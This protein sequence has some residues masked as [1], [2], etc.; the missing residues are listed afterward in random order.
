MARRSTLRSPASGFRWPGHNT[1]P[2]LTDGGR[3]DT[4][5]RCGDVPAHFSGRIIG[6][7]RLIS[8]L[9]RHAAPFFLAAGLAAPTL[10]QDIPAYQPRSERQI[11]GTG[12]ILD[13]PGGQ[14]VRAESPG[15]RVTIADVLFGP[16]GILYYQLDQSAS[17]A[18]VATTNAPNFCGFADRQKAGAPRFLALPN[19][20]HL[21][22]ASRRTL[23]EVNAFAAEHAAYLPTMSVYRADNGWFA[24]SLGQV[25]LAAAPSVLVNA[26]D[27][28]DD[29][30][31]SDGASY[32]AAM[33]LQDGRFFEPGTAPDGAWLRNACLT[34]DT[35]SCGPYASMIAP[36][37]DRSEADAA[38]I[39]RFRGIGCMAGDA[40]DCQM[41]TIVPV[42]IIDHVAQTAWPQSVD[43][44]PSQIIELFR[45]GC[46][47][48]LFKTCHY[49]AGPELQQI[50]GDPI[51]YITGL[52]AAAQGCAASQNQY[53]CRDMLRLLAKREKAMG[54]P[55]SPEDL[56]FFAGLRAASCKVPTAE[57][58]ESCPEV[59]QTY[60]AL[61][62]HEDAPP[63]Q[64][65]VALDYLR[66]RCDGGDPDACVIASGQSDLLDQT[67]RDR[68]AGQ[69]I[70]A[71]QGVEGNPT[72][73]RLDRQLGGELP[74]TAQLHQD[75]FRKLAEACQAGNSPEAADACGSAL[76]YFVRM[77][78][79]SETAP[80]EAALNA[81]CTP[82]LYA[83]CGDLA[84]YYSPHM[85]TGENLKFTGTNQ[86]EKRI[87]ALRIGCRPGALGLRNCNDLGE[88]LAVAGDQT[89]AQASYRMACNTIRAD[90]GRSEVLRADGS[91]F[92]AG[93][94]ALRKLGDR[95]IA[96]SDFSDVCGNYDNGNSP[97][98]CKHL[99]LMAI[100]DA[101]PEQGPVYT[102]DLLDQACYPRGDFIGDGEGCLYLG[103][104]LLEYRGRLGWQPEERTLSLRDAS[105][106][107]D[108]G[109][110]RAV[111]AASG[112]FANGCLSSW[113]A[114]CDA[115][116]QLVKDWATGAYP[117]EPGM[118]CQV[119]G[120]D[121]KLRSEKPC[122]A[123]RYSV[124]VIVDIDNRNIYDETA[125]IW[126]DGDRTVV[127][128]GAPQALLN[129]QPADV[130]MSEDGR[131]QCQRNPATGN[132][133][134]VLFGDAFSGDEEG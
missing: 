16:D 40:E 23:D 58:N 41:A 106:V 36:S 63:E 121:G 104:L 99:A 54:Q 12:Q 92:D 123:I 102:S 30:Y 90:G 64:V 87:A 118:T 89:G 7:F 98:A 134:C 14:P 49:L 42:N 22:A 107:G 67:E 19:S 76:S 125:Y 101:R 65:A 70:A 38:E 15:T 33:D 124:P 60:A 1:A 72:C 57:T 62:D 68:L 52:Q 26:R 78:S 35:K 103:R 48:G 94:H 21:I 132:E 3:P 119:W 84:F 39:L 25:S 47:A 56:F 24:V 133:F 116:D 51:R 111:K 34:G 109:L 77:I 96:A 74:Q 81:A 93:L 79:T 88:A 9:L 128:D 2:S 95:A 112:T 11:C 18:Y 6:G 110:V 80:L 31:C 129:G 50:S 115:N 131:K 75:E 97:Y 100:E 55:A 82:E 86:P 10:A 66:S 108:R 105:E 73:D 46:D 8:G 17:P 53:L 5:K 127:R 44:F 122:K 126:P 59:T 20:C 69:A 27:I 91:C 120:A 114:S 29:A 37:G 43:E 4:K 117:A 45:I 61:L 28:P 71:C 83:G 130:H 13:A 113:Q 32:T 85:M